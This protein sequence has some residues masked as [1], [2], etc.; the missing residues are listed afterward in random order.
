M[1]SD[2]YQAYDKLKDIKHM[3][4]WVHCRIR[5]Y[6]EA[7]ES[8]PTGTDLKA[9]ASYRLLHKI[10]KL[11]TIEKKNEGKSYEEIKKIR[12]DR[13]KPII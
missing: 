8:A 7:L 4:C 3:G 13:T 6:L 2:G 11:F 12:G 9:T 1:Q 10:N 5:K